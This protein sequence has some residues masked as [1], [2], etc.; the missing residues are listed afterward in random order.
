MKRSRSRSTQTHGQQKESIYLKRGLRKKSALLRSRLFTP[1]HGQSG[2]SPTTNSWPWARTCRSR[3]VTPLILWFELC[4]VSYTE[5]QVFVL[6]ASTT[7][8]SVLCASVFWYCAGEP[9]QGHAERVPSGRPPP[10]FWCRHCYPAITQVTS[11]LK[12]YILSR[13]SDIGGQPQL[14]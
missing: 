8:P 5:T 13:T 14:E 7:N 6:R 12:F 1:L 9:S 11:N 3:G 10:Q 4:Q 2:G